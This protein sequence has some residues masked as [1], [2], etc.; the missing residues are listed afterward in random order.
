MEI[1]EKKKRMLLY[2]ALLV[3]F[4]GISAFML[5]APSDG[6]RE[7][8]GMRNIV[9][10]IPEGETDVLNESKSSAYKGRE[11]QPNEVY[12]DRLGTAVADMG[13]ISLTSI[14]VGETKPVSSKPATEEI[15]TGELFPE[16]RPRTASSGNAR[17]AS[18]T[19]QQV[20]VMTQEERM[21]YD[22]KR[23]EAMRQVLME[24][25]DVK[26]DSEPDIQESV[27]IE[28]FSSGEDGIISSL[29]DEDAKIVPSAPKPVRCMFVKNEKVKNGQRVGI[30][31]LEDFRCGGI[32]IPENTHLAAVCSLS[33]RLELM[34]SS[35]EMNGRIYPIHLRAYD[36]D[37]Y[38]GIYCPETAAFKGR[39]KVAGEAVSTAGTALSGLVGGV[40]GKIVRTGASLLTSASG[41]QAVQIASGYEFYL[42][43]EVRR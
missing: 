17:P 34:V 42:M 5:C 16:T 43:E 21:E 1:D 27:K 33:G 6:N 20:P 19:R 30:R 29:D 18:R 39:K 24:D 11:R 23:A 10:E 25:P 7:D 26:P 40:A 28:S 31:I 9:I 3:V 38:E 2:I 36:I 13:H 22:L 8:E 41:E 32:V 12:Y 14:A 35:F 4:G 37:G 15:V